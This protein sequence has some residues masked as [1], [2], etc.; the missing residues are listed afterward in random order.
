MLLAVLVGVPLGIRAAPGRPNRHDLVLAAGD[1]PLHAEHWVF[2]DRSTSAREC[3]EGRRAATQDECHKAVQEAAA[4]EGLEVV[5]FKQVEDGAGLGVPDGCSYS[6][7]SK[8]ALF[9]TK[10]ATNDNTGDYQLVCLVPAQEVNLETFSDGLR[11]SKRHAR[12]VSVHVGNADW[13]SKQG[14]MVARYIDVPFSLYMSTDRSIQNETT[15][16]WVNATGNTPAYVV[17]REDL[18]DAE[19][20]LIERCILNADASCDH[21]VQLHHLASRACDADAP[22]E[23]YLIF[24]DSDAWPLASLK[25]RVLPLLDAEK[26]IE[27]VAVR[28]S[29]E[30]MALWPHPS[31][32]VTT[33]GA[34]TK[35]KHSFSQ[36]PDSEVPEVENERLTYAIFNASRGLLCHDH[37]MLDTGAPLWRHF[38]ETSKN[39][40]ALDRMN[41]LDIDPLFYGVYGPQPGKPLVFHQGAGSRVAATSKVT[42]AALQ[43]RGHGEPQPEA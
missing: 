37:F 7:H 22:D 41:K 3:T 5:G 42:T 25:R 11:P 30:G 28:R 26:G 20:T 1:T 21:G 4:R 15:Q 6:H 40:V 10:Y 31:F 38:N 33:C 9:N 27:L 43:V 18:R 19:T 12:V 39:W 35:N 36:P 24:L 14:E 17:A 8:K 13:V 2:E 23:D 16:K 29:I 32:A 34:W